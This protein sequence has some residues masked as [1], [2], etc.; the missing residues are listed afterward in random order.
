MPSCLQALAACSGVMGGAG[1]PLEPWH[2]G[3]YSHGGAEV[4]RGLSA[5][6]PP[7]SL[8]SKFTRIVFIPVTITGKCFPLLRISQPSVKRGPKA[9]LEN[10]PPFWR[11]APYRP[12]ESCTVLL[13]NLQLHDNR[14]PRSQH[15]QKPCH[16]AQ[17]SLN[18]NAHSNHWSAFKMQ[19]FILH[20]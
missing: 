16:R 14:V 3:L 18:L 1:Q 6:H 17:S 2:W 13:T 19:V 7:Q 10:F 11:S 5:T 4:A 15:P 8:P 9:T 12:G 20:I